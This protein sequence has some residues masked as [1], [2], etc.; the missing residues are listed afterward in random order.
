MILKSLSRKN[1]S[2]F[3]LITYMD[4]EKADKHS[5]LHRHCFTRGHKRLAGE[6]VE[7]SK[8]LKSRK[9]G[10]YLY[11]EILSIDLKE[12]VARDHAK[13]CLR[14]CYPYLLWSSRSKHRR[15]LFKKDRENQE[16]VSQ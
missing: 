3:Q 6:F 8:F 7:N 11:H 15:I 14:D 2:F 9:D 5:E 16:S 12:G 10:N 13:E 4:D 1:R